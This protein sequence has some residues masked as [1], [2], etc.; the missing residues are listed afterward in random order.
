[1]EGFR[2]RCQTCGLVLYETTEFYN[3]HQP[4]TGDMLRLLPL[5]KDWP[6]YDG[7]LASSGTPRFLMF[8]SQCAGYVFITGKLKFADFPDMKVTEISRE[9]SEMPWWD[10]V[11]EAEEHILK[12][13]NKF[14]ENFDGGN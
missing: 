7:S 9:R 4:L 11:N 12:K 8:C 6:T 2:V 5:Y 10:E 13:T 14:L 1:M 3:C